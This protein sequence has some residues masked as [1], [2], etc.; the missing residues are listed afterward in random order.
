MSQVLEDTL[1]FEEIA[2]QGFEKVL[3]ITDVKSKLKAIIC[4]HNT[5]L[6][7]ALGGTRM[8]PYPTF[9]AALNDVM[10]LARGMTIKSALAGTGLGGG[11]SVIIGD[12]K[13][14]KTEDLLLAFGR[15]M[16]R[17]EGQYICA[18]DYGMN[19]E[20]LAVIGQETPYIVDLPHVKSSGNPSVFT[21]WGVLRGMQAIMQKLNGNSSLVGKTVAIQGAGNVG[22]PLADLLFWQGAK[23]IISDIDRSKAEKVATKYAAE[24][25]APENILSVPC[26]ILAPCALGAVL[27]P[28][29][30]PQLRCRAVCGAANNQLLKD[31]DADALMRRGIIYAPDFIVNAGGVINVAEELTEEGYNPMNAQSRVHALYDQILLVLDIAERNHIST[32]AAAMSLYDYRI[33]YGIGKRLGPA[34]F[35]HSNLAK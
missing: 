21:A 34:Y 35:H 28:Q 32:Q 12:P 27:N 26:D 13:K 11:K 2:V 18:E 4:I 10:R 24:I 16:N 5:V 19:L 23:L 1:L 17:L 31:A 30:V 15:A 20:D 25:C 8:Y 7:P 6:G 22:V 9:E 14:D 33:K 29:T 3:K